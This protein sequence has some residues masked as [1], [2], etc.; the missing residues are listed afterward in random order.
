[1]VSDG[2]FVAFGLG[3]GL[4]G[5]VSPVISLVFTVGVAVY[6]YW[7][8]ARNAKATLHCSDLGKAM[9][10]QTQ[11][12]KELDEVL[13]SVFSL[14]SEVFCVYRDS[15]VLYA[16]QTLVQCGTPLL[17]F[18]QDHLS[19]DYLKDFLAGAKRALAGETVHV[20]IKFNTFAQPQRSTILPLSPILDAILERNTEEMWEL[21]MKRL[22]WTGQ[23]AVLIYLNPHRAQIPLHNFIQTFNHEFRTPLNIIIGLSDLI[24]SDREMP[25]HSL[26]QRQ[27][28]LRQC[29]CTLLATITSIIHQCELEWRMPTG[30]QHQAFTP[31]LEVQAALQSITG[32]LEKR[33]NSLRLDLDASI[34]EVLW[35]NVRQFRHAVAFIVQ[36]C[37]EI[38]QQ[39]TIYLAVTSNTKGEKCTL[40]GELSISKASIVTTSHFDSVLQLFS[41][42]LESDATQDSP[43]LHDLLKKAD[44]QT[45]LKLSVA[46]EM[47]RLFLGDLAVMDTDNFAV[48]FTMAFSVRRD[49]ALKRKGNIFMDKEEFVPVK[50]P[51]Y[52]LPFSQDVSDDEGSESL[53]ITHAKSQ[54]DILAEPSTALIERM[55]RRKTHPAVQCSANQPPHSL[56]D[57]DPFLSVG[58]TGQESFALIADDVPSNAYVLSTMQKRLGVKS[59][60]VS[61]GT[62]VLSFLEKY[63]PDVIFMDCEMPLM[64]GVE[65][66]RRIRDM[67]LTVPIVAVTASGPEKEKECIDAGM[68]LF[69]SKP[70]R[71]ERL[72]TLLHQLHL[73]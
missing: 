50:S 40:Q 7:L 45:M 31:K 68:D 19:Y 33:G 66:T 2:L 3:V 64:D 38:T 46:R 42:P 56:G 52:A 69:I 58:A 28:L 4:A 17:T 51:S 72:T 12:K 22:H 8:R 14:T 30:L 49:L 15:E 32:K 63:M 44:N 10:L 62:E 41:A 27:K 39:D 67:S 11:E 48:R 57:C 29:A 54:N 1:M 25:L 53:L 13:E 34:S 47:C 24:L 26:I 5:C 43:L 9:S 21:V 16:S 35:G 59:T 65:A 55:R 61:D 20:N 37:S 18:W 73:K 60:V 6:I 70:V 71:F 23:P 36:V